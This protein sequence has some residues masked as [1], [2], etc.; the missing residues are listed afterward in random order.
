MDEQSLDSVIDQILQSRK[1]RQL[2]I[3]RAT[4]A[5]LLIKELERGGKQSLAVKQAK[6]KL[7]NIMAPYLDTLDYAAAAEQIRDCFITETNHEVQSVC[8]R[9][10]S[11]HD[12]TR[13]RLPY[14]RAFYGYLFE[15]IGSDCTILDLACGLSPFF[16]PLVPHPTAMRYLAYDIHGP[17]IAL[18]NE[19][20][21]RTGMPAQAIKQDILV[22][23]PAEKAGVAFLFKEAHRIEKRESGG[24][25]KL[26]EAI[27]A[28]RIFI[29]LPTHSLNG[30]FDLKERMG[31]LV[32]SM[33]EGFAYLEET[34]EFGSEMIYTI[35]KIDG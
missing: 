2:D 8:K 11:A 9:I 23:P 17:R 26:I 28:D 4:I 12:S 24:S 34:M 3:P 7:H 35:R 16:L 32:R 19:L 22:N 20:F 10:L 31:R 18:L 5:D 14:F 25:R 29:S 30:R 15:R 33:I 6:A 27:Q 21:I 1:Y 13:E